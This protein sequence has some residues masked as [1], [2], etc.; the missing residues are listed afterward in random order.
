MASGTVA[1][2]SHVEGDA[3]E[4]S[5][6]LRRAVTR[7]G[8]E[9]ITNAVRHADATRIRLDLRFEPGAI[10]LS[11]AD[12]GCG[13]DVDRWQSEATDHYGL[14]SMRERAEDIGAQLSVA[15]EKGRGTIVQLKAPLLDD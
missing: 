6:K 12:D 14:V 11:V 10:D 7:I 4:Y 8:Q 5:A 13:F 3:P 15:S 1:F 2:E 9:A